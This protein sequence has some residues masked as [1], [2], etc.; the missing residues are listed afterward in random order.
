MRARAA[1]A[2]VT[3]VA[4]LIVPAAAKSAFPGVNGKIAYERAAIDFEIH[5]MD[6][7]GSHDT[8]LTLGE[9]PSW[10]PDGTRIAF[11]DAGLWIMNA[12]GSDR[13]QIVAEDASGTP[14]NPAWSPAGN[15]L[16]FARRECHPAGGGS[17]DCTSA[18]ETVFDDG[19]GETTLA[20]GALPKLCKPAWS[21]DGTEILL[22]G[23]QFAAGHACY[24]DLY[25]IQPDGTGLRALTN[26]G[27][28][29]Q[30]YDQVDW[31]PDSRRLLVSLGGFYGVG[32]VNR[33]ATTDPDGT[34]I[35]FTTKG[36]WSPDGRRF[37]LV[38][39]GMSYAYSAI[40]VVHTDGAEPH[41]LSRP[42]SVDTE[43]DWQ[44]LP[45][46]GY[47]RPKGASPLQVP[48]VPT[49]K[50]CTTTNSHH[51]SPLAFPSC[52]PPDHASNN[53]TMGTPDAN[54]QPANAIASVFY[55][56][57]PGDAKVAIAMRDIRS[58]LALADY[59]GELQLVSDLRITDRNNTPN[60]G[61]PG[62]GTVQNAPLPVTVSCTGTA[63]ATIGSDCN[64]TTTVN[65]VHPGALTGGL[66]SVWELGQ[67]HV[68]DGGADGLVSTAGD[69]TLF[70]TQGLF[71]P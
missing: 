52:S 46:A 16:A 35:Q 25:S 17:E 62:P 55:A 65:A 44:P 24:G 3:L 71:I 18:V 29:G 31:S 40:Y 36:A 42:S 70:L 11:S 61:G 13:H 33:D 4:A 69:N 58:N 38:G 15:K 60:P 63:S 39:D 49:Y 20:S 9:E 37:V 23:A 32:T 19:T 34:F 7:D 41:K 64:L 12:D 59:I 14:I 51:G 56:A 8:F 67:V 57:R 10:S 22:I 68:Y 54:G 47:P 1:I 43:P 50:Q 66:R 45:N 30:N 48:L 21:P 6:P 5:V 26:S 28:S 2:L 53:L 27:G